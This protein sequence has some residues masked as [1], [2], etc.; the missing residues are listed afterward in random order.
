VSLTAGTDTVTIRAAS[1]TLPTFEVA[2]TA[3]ISN[4]FALNVGQTVKIASGT[5]TIAASA[6]TITGHWSVAPNADVAVPNLPKI[7]ISSG[8]KIDN[9]GN[10]SDATRK[11]V[12][13]D[14]TGT[15]IT[16]QTNIPAGTYVLTNTSLTTGGQNN[17]KWGATWKAQ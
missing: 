9:K 8:A 5:T 3:T 7:I 4:N 2:G 1:N 10:V 6:G 11:A 12:F 17:G 16:D 14:N 15:A 13:Q